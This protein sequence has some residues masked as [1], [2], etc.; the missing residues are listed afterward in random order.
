MRQETLDVHY[1]CYTCESHFIEEIYPGAKP[2]QEAIHDCGS[3]CEKTD[4]PYAKLRE[5]D[6]V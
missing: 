2:S 6:E 5:D 1:Y 4:S 3:L